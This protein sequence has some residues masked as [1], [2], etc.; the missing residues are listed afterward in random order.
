MTSV[1]M[2]GQ[3]A[4]LLCTTLMVLGRLIGP[5]SVDDQTNNTGKRDSGETEEGGE[6]CKPGWYPR[7]YRPSSRWGKEN[8]GTN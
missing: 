2:Q 7:L 4:H 5:V 1:R 3:S 6:A 8:P